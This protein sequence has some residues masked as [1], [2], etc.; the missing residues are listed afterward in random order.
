VGYRAYGLD[1]EG[2]SHG[3]FLDIISKLHG[4]RRK[5]MNNLN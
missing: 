4:G 3:Q 1:V 2:S 5:V